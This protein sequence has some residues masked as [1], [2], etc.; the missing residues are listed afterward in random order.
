MDSKYKTF[1]INENNNYCKYTD[2]K[3]LQIKKSLKLKYRSNF[4]IPEPQR[5]AEVYIKNIHSLILSKE[6][7]IQKLKPVIVNIVSPSFDG[8]PLHFYDDFISMKTNFYQTIDSIDLYPIQKNIVYVPILTVIRDANFDI[9]I[10]FFYSICC[11]TAALVNEP[12]IIE[13]KYMNFNDHMTC[14]EVIESIFQTAKLADHDTLIL[15]DFGC[16]YNKVPIVDL[17]DILNL[18]ILK[19]G[20]FFKNIYFSIP[21]SSEFD[22]AIYEYFSK[23]II[24][25]QDI[26]DNIL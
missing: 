8:T 13:E 20:G 6:C 10:K 7:L 2:H 3:N 24:K 1:I 5:F 26:S 19:Y 4:P 15:T 18:L 16:K 25:P 12:E 22:L 14:L 21:A 11:I 23:N 17:V 9:N